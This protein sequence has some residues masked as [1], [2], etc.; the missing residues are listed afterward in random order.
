MPLGGAMS[1]LRGLATPPFLAL[2]F[3]NNNDMKGLYLLCASMLLA[4]CSF[5]QNYRPFLPGKLHY[6]TSGQNYSLRIDSSGEVAGDSVFWM[7]DITIPSPP[8]CT[9][10]ISGNNWSMPHFI[11]DKEGFFGDHFICR[12]NGAYQFVSRQGDT[13]TFHTRLPLGTTWNFLSDSSLTASITQRGL[14]NANGIVDSM[15]RIDIS[16]GQQY[17]LTMENGLFSGPNLSYYLH[18]QNLNPANL[19]EPPSWHDFKDFFDWQPGDLYNTWYHTNTTS[20]YD[21]YERWLVLSRVESTSGDSLSFVFKHWVGQYW[22]PTGGTYYWIDTVSVTHKREDYDFINLATYEVKFGP[23]EYHRQMPWSYEFNNHITLPYLVS[24]SM[25]WADSCGFVPAI[26]PE[27]SSPVQRRYTLGLGNTYRTLSI[28]ST[29]TSCLYATDRLLCYELAGQDS[30]LPCLTN[31]VI[32]AQ[33]DPRPTSRLKLLRNSQSGEISILWEG[34]AF[35]NYQWDLIDMNGRVIR[36][37]TKLMEPLGS[38]SLSLPGSAGIYL[39]RISEPSGT[40]VQT[41]RIPIMRN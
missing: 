38:H 40:W 1:I 8:Q 25:G 6:F 20:G 33:T 7:N 41:M 3:K 24:A 11:G 37:E 26:I 9:V 16:D 19:V 32:L 15:I 36:S 30:V 14:V 21:Q 13:A 39:I 17:Q 4:A 2:P 28:G 31:L 12:A 34:F 5:S 23:T 18:G 27:C 29:T 10:W 35:G 22:F